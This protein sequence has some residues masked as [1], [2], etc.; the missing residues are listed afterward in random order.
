MT[1]QTTF[2][3]VDLTPYADCVGIASRQ[4]LGA[5]GFNIWRNTFPA[6]D[7]PGGGELRVAGVPFRFPSSDGVRPDNI[8]CRGQLIELDDGRVDWV[9]LLAAAERRT[10][11]PLTVHYTGGEWRRQWLRVSDFWPETEPRFG[12]RLAYR[13]S[14]LLYPRHDH[15]GFAP[16]MWCTRVP[17]AVPD[18]VCALSLPENPAMHVFSLTLRADR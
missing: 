3:P 5:G 7:L 6:E 17:V 12:D 4:A 15:Q 1:H 18:G 10:E 13:T 14:T 2:R 16:A 11:D 9:Y 8:R